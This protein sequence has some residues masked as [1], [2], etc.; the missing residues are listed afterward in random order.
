MSEKRMRIA[1][2]TNDGVTVEEHFGHC[3]KFLIVDV[4]GDGQTT[5]M[6][7]D[8]PEHAPGVFPKYLGEHGVTAIITGGMGQMAVQLFKEQQI[9]VILGATGPISENL[10]VYLSGELESTGSVCE[11]N[12]H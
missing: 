8:P 5:S 3:R 10:S 2:P 9:E 1:F 6:A 12:H 11:H 4:D 7:L